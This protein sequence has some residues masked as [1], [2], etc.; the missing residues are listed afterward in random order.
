MI[1][2]FIC[3]PRTRSSV[4]FE[5][6]ASYIEAAYDIPTLDE[7]T[8]LFLHTSRNATYVDA[9]TGTVHDMELMPII[10]NNELSIHYIWPHVYGS[11][12]EATQGKFQT[13]ANLKSM[14]QEYF[15]KGTLQVVEADVRFLEFWADRKFIFTLRE[16]L[17]EL[18]ASWLFARHSRIFHM[19]PN[20]VQ[21]YHEALQA[22]MTVEKEIID[23]L[24]MLFE[25][26]E[27]IQKA[28]NYVRKKG[29]ANQVVYYEDLDTQMAID[30]TVTEILGTEDWMKVRPE[31]KLLPIKVA[32]NYSTLITNYD[33]IENEV[34]K[35]KRKYSLESFLRA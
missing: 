32:K 21:N 26:L 8:E 9:K 14:G 28:I 10:K 7:H 13:L 30:R 17:V 35:L 23:Q 1:P 22:G 4:L 20:N 2:Q 31:K 33:Q 6:C 27:K 15:I 24:W 25:L 11:P 3:P 5:T 29:W 34:N 16:N 12:K 18:A 19:R